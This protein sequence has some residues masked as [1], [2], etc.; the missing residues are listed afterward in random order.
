M[1]WPEVTKYR[2][3]VSA[4][5][6]RVEIIQDMFKVENDPQR[7]VVNGGMIRLRGTHFALL[8][9]FLVVLFFILST[10]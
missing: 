4:Q 2:A 1:D 6:H 7:G 5:T 10:F 8:I 3:L 9:F